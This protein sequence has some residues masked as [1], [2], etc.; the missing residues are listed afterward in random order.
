MPAVEPVVSEE[1][2]RVEAKQG[3]QVPFNQNHIER[4]GPEMRR[5]IILQILVKAVRMGIRAMVAEDNG[6]DQH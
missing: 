1:T 6:E 3:E 4:M 5:K 2:Q